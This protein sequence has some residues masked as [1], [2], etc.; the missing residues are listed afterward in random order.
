[1]SRI[2]IALT[3][4]IAAFLGGVA[5]A[6]FVAHRI[7]D[8]SMEDIASRLTSESES[9]VRMNVITLKLLQRGDVA[10]AIHINCMLARS[11]LPLLAYAE[12]VPERKQSID[13]LASEAEHVIGE[14]EA[15]D[16]CGS[17]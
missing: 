11:S 2:V 10:Q 15:S 3:I 13:K 8:R 1:M 4:T 6:W 16:K 17:P 5:G 9:R 14:L 7:A 12:G